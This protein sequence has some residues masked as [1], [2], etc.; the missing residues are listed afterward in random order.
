VVE[1]V[2]T[3]GGVGRYLN[4]VLYYGFHMYDVLALTYDQTG[5]DMSLAFDFYVPLEGSREDIVVWGETSGE[6]DASA[7]V[8]VF[9]IDLKA[10]EDADAWTWYTEDEEEDPGAVVGV[11][12]DDDDGDGVADFEDDSIGFA[13]GDGNDVTDDVLADVLELRLNEIMTDGQ[14]TEGEVTLR[15]RAA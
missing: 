1:A 15:V 4:Y 10:K 8:T 5:E 6:S 3:T 12:S 7:N 11:D 9:E 2:G 14:V 13:D